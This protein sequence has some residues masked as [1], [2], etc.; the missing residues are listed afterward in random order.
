MLVWGIASTIILQRCQGGEQ[1]RTAVARALIHNPAIILADEPTGN[2]DSATGEDVMAMLRELNEDFGITLILVTHDDEVAQYA[3]RIVR[4][5][6]G[7][8]KEIVEKRDVT[9]TAV[10]NSP[11]TS[12]R[13]TK[14]LA[15]NSAISSITP[16]KTYA[17]VQCVMY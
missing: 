9:E 13:K 15:S 3:N 10:S 7:R 11:S 8:I 17:V 6:D 1:Q 16:Y 14:K 2:L 12:N 5:R 4:L